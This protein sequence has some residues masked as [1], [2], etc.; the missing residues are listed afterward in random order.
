MLSGSLSVLM[1]VIQNKGNRSKS[2]SYETKAAGKKEQQHLCMF[3][4][5]CDSSMNFFRVLH[6]KKNDTLAC[7]CCRCLLV[8]T[9]LCLHHI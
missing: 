5:R 9:I 1:P 4:Q 8:N 2:V 3:K 7:R 6:S